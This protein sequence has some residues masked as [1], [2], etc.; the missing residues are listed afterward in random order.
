MAH[1]KVKAGLNINV[2]WCSQGQTEEE[3]GAHSSRVT[4]KEQVLKKKK[5]YQD[6]AG[7]LWLASPLHFSFEF[8]H[9]TET[10]M[11]PAHG[12]VMERDMGM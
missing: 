7:F 2:C 4:H 6:Q 8:R 9:E 10:W 11:V 12:D 5:C 3:D 1:L